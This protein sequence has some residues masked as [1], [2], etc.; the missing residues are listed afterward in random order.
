MKS[1]SH[2]VDTWMTPGRQKA[3]E[4]APAGCHGLAELMLLCTA[5][6]FTTLHC[7]AFNV[8]YCTIC[9][10][11]HRLY[12]TALQCTALLALHYTALYCTD[13]TVLHCTA[14]HCTHCTALLALHCTTFTAAGGFGH[15]A[16]T[17]FHAR[18]GNLA[19]IQTLPCGQAQL[20]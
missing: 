15:L 6:Y 4:V 18:I 1:G 3:P 12:C 16:R 10:A 5:L 9:T 19:N 2:H 11:L 7:T 13:C 17:S 14:L 20:T 8:L